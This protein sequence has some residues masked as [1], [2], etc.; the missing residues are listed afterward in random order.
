MSEDG[1]GRDEGL[2]AVGS[3]G[4]SS[5]GMSREDERMPET[6]ALLKMPAL[7]NREI[8]AGQV[9]PA[10]RVVARL[11]HGLRRRPLKEVS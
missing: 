2:V 9:Q 7:G 4:S 5:T 6:V 8:E 3:F 1:V 11:G 10:G